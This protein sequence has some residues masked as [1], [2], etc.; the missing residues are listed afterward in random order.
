[1]PYYTDRKKPFKINEPNSI[2]LLFIHIPK[3][4]G[5]IIEYKIIRK[6]KQSMYSGARNPNIPPYNGGSLQHQ[7]YST[8][9]KYRDELEI[10][11][12][13]IKIFCLVRNPYD[14]IISDLLWNKSIKKDFT[15]DQV[16]DVIKNNYLYRKNLDNHN[17]PQYKFVI[18]EN[19]EVN[20]DIK[21]FKCEELNEIN[22]EL[23]KF[24]GFNI[25][26]KQENVNKDYS[27]YL[28]KNSISLIN[29]F[30]KKDFELF[31]Y[32]LK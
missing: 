29:E 14:R 19:L 4:G 2:N 23:N 32:D 9:Y 3:T 27:M 5:S 11:F 30:Y 18:D 31:N 7:F 16:Y 17:V 1:M 22:D 15:A 13:N 24:L 20:P 10:N 21:I 28:N 25:N 12:E 8:L 26:I 6:Y